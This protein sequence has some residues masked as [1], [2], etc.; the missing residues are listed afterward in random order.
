VGP[1]LPV[2]WF[3]TVTFIVT[4]LPAVIDVLLRVTLGVTKSGC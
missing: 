3:R 1:A 4:L 2:P